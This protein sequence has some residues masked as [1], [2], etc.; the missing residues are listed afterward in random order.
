MSKVLYIA[1][2]LQLVI[3]SA[4]LAQ[5]NFVPLLPIESGVSEPRPLLVDQPSEAESILNN[6]ATG[7][8]APPASQSNA[9][10]GNGGNDNGTNPAQNATTFIL[11]NE[12]YYLQGGNQINTTY[13]RLEYPWYDK[14]GALLFE[15]PFVYYDFTASSPAL[16]QIG[17]LGDIRIQTSFNTWTSDDK[18]IT[19]INL[20]EAFLPTADNA[21][22][23]RGQTGNTITAFNLG[24][25]KYVLGPGIGLVYAISP[26]AIIAPLYF[27]K[28]QYLGMICD[29]KS[30]VGNSDSL[31]CMH[32]KAAYMFC[33]N[34]KF[35]LTS[36]T[37]TM[38]FMWHRKLA[39]AEKGQ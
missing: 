25:G 6:A 12:Y 39:I 9:N 29:R 28:H 32:G 36:S 37:V 27:M 10:Q 7:A 31:V 20:F 35:L 4:T 15:I 1:L 34:C 23:A 21:I 2:G 14:R 19:V 17:G 11:S 8:L 30:A 5:E 22:A 26:N 16:P 18:K 13:A 38:I 24:T 33:Q 3:I